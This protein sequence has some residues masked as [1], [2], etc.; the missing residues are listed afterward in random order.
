MC[1]Y[2]ANDVSHKLSDMLSYE[3]NKKCDIQLLELCGK[4]ITPTGLVEA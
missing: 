2:G 1:D 4:Y 3:F